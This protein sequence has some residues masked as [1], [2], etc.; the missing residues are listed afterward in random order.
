MRDVFGEAKQRLAREIDSSSA[1][2]AEP[3]AADPWLISSLLQKSI[4][5]GETDIARRAALTLSKHRGAAIWRRLIV[6]AFEDIGIAP[7]QCLHVHIQGDT[8]QPNYGNSRDKILHIFRVL[9][10]IGYQRTVSS[11]HPWISTRNGPFDYAYDS[12]TT[13]RFLEDLR[14]QVF[15]T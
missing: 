12:A 11:A 5:R 10:D 3:I 2:L 9:R 4:R 8:Y 15:P 1:P 13:L 6:I 14:E 7:D